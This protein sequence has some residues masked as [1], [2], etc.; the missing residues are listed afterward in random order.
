MLLNASGRK[1]N[2]E[3]F[4]SVFASI[5]FKQYSVKETTL[6]NVVIWILGVFS[7]YIWYIYRI[8]QCYY[9][10]LVRYF[11]HAYFSWDILLDQM[12]FA[13][14]QFDDVQTSK[15]Q[16]LL[17]INKV[18]RHIRMDPLVPLLIKTLFKHLARI[19]YTLLTDKSSHTT[20]K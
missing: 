12:V 14:R 15:Q 1:K 2:V 4:C 18:N 11:E 10:S 5:W 16:S 8:H 3:Q 13:C 17:P 19:I 9:R 7:E 20:P 6:S